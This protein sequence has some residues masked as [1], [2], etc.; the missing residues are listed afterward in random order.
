MKLEKRNRHLTPDRRAKIERLLELKAN[1]TD[2]IQERD[3]EFYEDG[4]F[5]ELH[6]LMAELYPIF[7]VKP[8]EDAEAKLRGIIG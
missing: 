7:G 1:H 4:R 6:R 2:A 3:D 5:D 8:W